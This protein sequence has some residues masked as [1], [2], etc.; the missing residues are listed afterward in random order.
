MMNARVE[1][2]PGF[3]PIGE[4]PSRMRLVEH[5]NQKGWFIQ[6]GRKG[7]AQKRG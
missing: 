3:A 7:M 1:I 5:F 6:H 2:H 4:G